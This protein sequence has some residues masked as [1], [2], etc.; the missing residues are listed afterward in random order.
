MASSYLSLELVLRSNPLSCVITTFQY[1]PA[2]E[3]V[4]FEIRKEAFRLRVISTLR[5]DVDAVRYDIE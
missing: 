4:H 1:I 2:K 5:T 3:L